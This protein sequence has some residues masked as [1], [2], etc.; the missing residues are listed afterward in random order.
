[1][2]SLSA[3][4]GDAGASMTFM[5]AAVQSGRAGSVMVAGRC[6]TSCSVR[7]SGASRRE[8]VTH[9]SRRLGSADAALA[10]Y[11]AELL[12]RY[13]RAS[14]ASFGARVCAT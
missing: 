1:M 2:L 13:V 5:W 9:S 14:L 6:A 11:S 7:F 3:A 12:A 8:G 4:T 10:N